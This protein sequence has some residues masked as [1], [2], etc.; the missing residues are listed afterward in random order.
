[1][2][3]N[4]KDMVCTSVE[5]TDGHS[6][7]LDGITEREIRNLMM[8]A[9]GNVTCGMGA[10]SYLEQERGYVRLDEL[11]DDGLPMVRI[12]GYTV[13]ATE[14]YCNERYGRLKKKL[15][16]RLNVPYY[17]RLDLRQILMDIIRG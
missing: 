5:I 14:A 17:V 13:S 3:D 12:N 7:S 6:I 1:M 4:N 9:N 8:Y 15:C 2:K 10:V 16:D 11:G